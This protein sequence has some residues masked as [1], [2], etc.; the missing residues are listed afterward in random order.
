MAK[1]GL[2]RAAGSIAMVGAFVAM[3]ACSTPSGV[4]ELD[5][6]WAS[7]R[8]QQV[9]VSNNSAS[10]VF[11]MVI[12]RNA[13]TRVDWYPCIDTVRCPPIQPGE[14]QVHPYG[15]LL[16]DP[17]ETE[18]VIRLWRAVTDVSGVTHAELFGPL[19]LPLR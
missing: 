13:E 7:A 14:S 12:G 19:I 9:V 4:Q 6:V 11:S 17:G 3:E 15:N 10:A 1:S 5:G 16:L 18:V 2:F 8:N